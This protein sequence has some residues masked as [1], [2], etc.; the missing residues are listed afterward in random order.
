M[1]EA[2]K[3]SEALNE[4]GNYF[5]LQTVDPVRDPVMACGRICADFINE[6]RRIEHETPLVNSGLEYLMTSAV[7]AVDK[8]IWKDATGTIEIEAGAKEA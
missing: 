4:A 7:A 5:L 3:G 8:P 6:A 2:K 1:S